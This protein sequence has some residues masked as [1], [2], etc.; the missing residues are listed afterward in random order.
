VGLT[1]HRISQNMT[2]KLPSGNQTWQSG[3]SLN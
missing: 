2:A 1:E 3:N